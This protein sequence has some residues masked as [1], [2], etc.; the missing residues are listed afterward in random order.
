MNNRFIY[1]SLEQVSI[2]CDGEV[3]LDRYWCIHPDKGIAFWQRS[4]VGS[5]D[6][7]R[8]SPQCNSDKRVTDHM[9]AQRPDHVVQLVPAVYIG[10]LNK[11][12]PL[13]R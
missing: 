10:N 9:C 12:Y 8:L 6:L 13:D 2:P 3:M 7:E 4:Y 1:A 11:I 5:Y